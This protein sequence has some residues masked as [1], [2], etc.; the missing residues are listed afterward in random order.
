MFIFVCKIG[1]ER[2]AMAV[3]NRRTS[4][5]TVTQR[6]KYAEG[7][8]PPRYPMP[9]KTWDRDAMLLRLEQSIK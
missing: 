8:F 2:I 9:V 1:R 6:M 7:K 3:P 5:I 4:H